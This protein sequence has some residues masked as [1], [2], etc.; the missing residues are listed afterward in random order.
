MTVAALLLELAM[1]GE[2]RPRRDELLKQALGSHG[3]RYGAGHDD[4]DH[5]RTCEPPAQERASAQ[6]KCAAKTCV[7]A[8]ITRIKNK[9]T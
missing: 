4:T 6:K 7:L 3:R 5:E 2:D 8:A 9:G 1:P